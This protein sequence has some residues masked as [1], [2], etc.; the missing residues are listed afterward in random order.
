MPHPR[1]F[2]LR[3]RPWDL[4]FP[5]SRPNPAHRIALVQA[6]WIFCFNLSFTNSTEYEW[7]PL[8]TG[9]YTSTEN[10]CCPFL[11]KWSYLFFEIK[12]SSCARVAPNKRRILFTQRYCIHTKISNQKDISINNSSGRSVSF[13]VCPTNIFESCLWVIRNS[14][15]LASASL[16]MVVRCVDN[17]KLAKLNEV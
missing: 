13:D 5:S 6:Y 9:L 15:F 14:F 11:K 17:V 4:C 7:S 10:I 2:R 8:I 12:M 1:M 3:S 16:Y